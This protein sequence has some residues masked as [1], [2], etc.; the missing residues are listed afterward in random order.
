MLGNGCWISQWSPSGIIDNSPCKS[1]LSCSWTGPDQCGGSFL[2]GQQ[3]QAFLMIEY[4]VMVLPRVLVTSFKGQ[5]QSDKKV[6]WVLILPPPARYLLPWLLCLALLGSVPRLPHRGMALAMAIR[7]EPQ[8][9][10]C[11]CFRINPGFL[12]TIYFEAP[13]MWL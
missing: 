10:S 3:P 11:L 12:P 5:D 1:S 2:V 4:A 7:A 13:L 6:G 9:W 8:S